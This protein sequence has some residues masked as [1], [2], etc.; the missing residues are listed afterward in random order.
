MYNQDPLLTTNPRDILIFF[1][2]FLCFSV[3]FLAKRKEDLYTGLLSS[4]KRREDDA[5]RKL[6]EISVLQEISDRIS[7]SL[8]IQKIAEIII[9]SVRA[10]FE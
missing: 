10:L 3:I 1:L 9:D 5:E 6:F 7:Y 4:L 2:F 8:D